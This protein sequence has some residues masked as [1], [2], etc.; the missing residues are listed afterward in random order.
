M[1]IHRE[2]TLTRHAELRFKQR[3]IGNHTLNC[4]LKYGEVNNAPGGA[5]IITL[6]SRIAEKEICILRKEIRRIERSRGM[7]VI[8]KDGCILTGY[9]KP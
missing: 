5:E 4:L 1:N 2:T 6:P 3:G 7:V 9:R 8:Q